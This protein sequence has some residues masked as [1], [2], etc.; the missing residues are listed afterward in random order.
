MFVFGLS[1]FFLEKQILTIA[2]IF[3][4]M[5]A[6]EERKWFWKNLKIHQFFVLCVP[7]ERERE[8]EREER[9]EHLYLRIAFL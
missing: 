4:F 9:D 1:V 5:H 8:R 2:K 3:F 6:T 7:R